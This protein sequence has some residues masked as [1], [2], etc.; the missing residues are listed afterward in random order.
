ME[1]ETKPIAR[2]ATEAFVAWCAEDTPAAKFERTVA[3][4]VVGAVVA[5]VTTGIWG[6]AF[7]TALVMAVLAP[8]QAQI[9]RK[10]D[11]WETVITYGDK[12]ER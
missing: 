11:D 7:A 1:K 8:V 3:Q 6:A 10:A 5:G 4:G 9:G 12:E 2:R